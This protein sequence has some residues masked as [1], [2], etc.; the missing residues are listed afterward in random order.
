MLAQ[1]SVKK[2]Y[3]VI[4]AAILIIVLGVISFTNMITD[5]L[6]A[7]DLPYVVVIT[8]YPGASPEKVEQMVTKPLEAVLGT[9]SGLKNISSISSENSST[10][11]LEYLQDTNM[12]SVMI[13]LSSSIDMVS[14]QFED[15]VGTPILLKIS[16]D[17][18]PIVVASVDY[19]GMDIDELSSFTAD[20]VVPAFERIDGVASVT[21]GGLIE[22]QLEIVL[23]KEKIYRLNSQVKEEVEKKLDESRQALEEAQQEIAKGRNALERESPGKQKQIAKASAELNNAIANLNALLAEEQLLEAQKAAF[24]KEKEELEKLVQL[25]QLFEQ[26]FPLG[27]KDLPP[28][29][30]QA[31]IQQIGDML[32][33][34]LS[35]L[36]QQEMA[37]LAERAA[38]AQSRIAAID[39]ELQNINVR[40]LTHKA[41]KPQLENAVKEARTALE[42]LESG[43]ITM[44]VELAKAQIQLDNSEKELEKGL[45]E[46]EKRKEEALAGADLHKILTQDLIKKII[47][48]QNFS[49]P[50]GYIIQGN[51]QH[52]VKVGDSFASTEE[53]KDM[54]VFNIDPVG[55][56]RLSDIADIELTDNASEMYTKVNGNVGIILMFQ[57]QSTASTSEVSKAIN[58]QIEKLQAQYKGLKIRPMMDQGDYIKM[59][60]DSVIE[61]L[62]YGGILA[63]IVLIIFLLDVRP[64]IVI[65]LSIPISLMF[66]VTLMYFTNITLNVISLSGLALAVGMLVDNSIVVIE[67][68]YR[69]RHEGLPASKAAV[70]GTK[71]V[72]GAIIASTLTTVCVFLPIVFTQGLSRQLFADMGLT[73]GYSLM[74]SLL[75]ALT[76]VP[77]LGSKLLQRT[78]EKKQR[79]FVVRAYEKLLRFVLRRKAVVLIPVLLLFVLSIYFTTVMGTAFMPDVDSPQISA[80]LSMPEDSD[81]DDL[82]AMSDEVMKRILEIDDVE[83]VGAI[84]GQQSGMAMLGRG[85]D[86]Q[87]TFYILLKDERDLT[88]KDVER[89]IYEKTKDLEC[90]IKV[91][92]ATMDI[93]MLSGRGIQVNIKGQNLDTLMEIS[94]D[95]AGI[96]RDI[97]GVATVETGLEDAEKETRIM[98][99]KDKAMREGLTV[100]Q[101]YAEIS[102]ALR[103]QSQATV[104]SVGN[105][106]YPVLLVKKDQEGIT[107][108]NIGD[109]AF[110]VT[111]KD[112][113]E[114]EIKLKDIAEIREVDSLESIRRENQSRYMTVTA[115]IADGYNIGLV[116][117]DV[118]AKL[119]EYN[120]PDGYEINLEGENEMIKETMRDLILM[121]ALAIA[122]IYL[123]M[124]AQFENLL[125]P[126][127]VFFT[128][129]LAFTGGLLLLWIVGMEL[130]V[131]AL[132][133]FLV[134]AGIVVNNGIVFVDY[135]NQLRERGL[136][137][138]EALVQAG[139]TRVRPILMTALTT[140]LALT[141]LAL[142]Y[143]SGAEMM[144]PMAVVSIGGLTYATLLTLFV[145]PIMYDLFVAN[146][147]QDNDKIP[148]SE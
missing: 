51:N 81:R 76:L 139:V 113:T 7:M 146:K 95:I 42:Q 79:L 45:D 1:Y 127:I 30:Y 39:V 61:N 116:S 136:D 41:M 94:N 46:F 130:S 142:G 148:V 132:V 119:A 73:I 4:V 65:A 80:T 117:R 89:L 18:I 9:S 110:T 5:L 115:E 141:T 143:G 144:Q 62:L 120:T 40:Q 134:L 37:E 24:E 47:A 140:I 26:L 131:I 106:N 77:V 28:E 29:V 108:A 38:N 93:T 133:G 11:V 135:V 83:T 14:A 91:D 56:I 86:N 123:I 97:K 78:K 82:Y 34:E 88:N 25:N 35:G 50:A 54:V 75:V 52:L 59:I 53:I 55:D 32:P 68:I 126:F 36:S 27:I 125:S 124:V 16:P 100:A 111:Q 6:P 145:V 122:L 107:K 114:K 49:M 8:S 3:T 64:T 44:A 92:T 33:E 15:E 96:L 31:T 69:L 48:A 99:D 12:D 10:I 71:E 104:L 147:K 72:S 43:K 20:T 90:E 70:E 101:I 74:A 138:R 23:D 105:D 118:E 102:E 112:G 109:Y 17:M 103:I 57:K 129:P 21:A 58:D 22:K 13:E 66:A 2:P 19:E 121:I 128:L 67:N 87:T 63:I 98:V 85:S 60:T 84:S 137:K